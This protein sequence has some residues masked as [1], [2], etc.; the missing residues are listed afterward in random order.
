MQPAAG[1]S[2]VPGAARA[3]A[4]SVGGVLDRH[5]PS[6]GRWTPGE[7]AVSDARELSSLLDELGW[8]SLAQ[9]EALL[10]F[11]G[12][13]AV[14]LGRRLAPLHEV[15]RL[16]GGGPMVGDLVR[17]LGP[18]RVAVVLERGGAKRRTV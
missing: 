2:D 16:L 10:A 17:S 3:F 9:D 12:L 7:A 8:M 18:E 1:L 13:G 6:A 11:A 14:E 5:G 15:D 4:Q